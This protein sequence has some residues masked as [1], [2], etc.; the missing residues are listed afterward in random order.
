MIETLPTLEKIEIE[1]PVLFKFLRK[2]K[3]KLYEVLNAYEVGKYDEAFKPPMIIDFLMEEHELLKRHTK[4]SNFCD[5]D[6]E[7]VPD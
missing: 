6:D 5:S 7:Y 4:N 1:A 3:N 2:T